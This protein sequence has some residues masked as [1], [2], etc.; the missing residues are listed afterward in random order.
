MINV[1]RKSLIN[2]LNTTCH[3][4]LEAAV[5]LCLSRMHD[6]VDLEHLFVKL[7]AT[8]DTDIERIFRHYQINQARL[9][10][11][12]ILALERVKK[13]N[14]RTPALSPRLLN[15]VL[16]AW[17]FASINFSVEKIRSGQLLL[18]LLAN[19]GFLQ[20]AREISAEFSAI[21]A[22]SL[23]HHFGDIVAGSIEDC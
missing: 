11:D 5:G 1:D 23:H 6:E 19:D 10:Q 9:S 12:I 3:S 7:I 17:V 20:Q 4:A 22:E 21:S 14:S 13:C 2:R 15:L 18:A 8:P 16:E